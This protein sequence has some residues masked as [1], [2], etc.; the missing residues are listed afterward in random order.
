MNTSL[1]HSQPATGGC[2][3]VREFDSLCVRSF[4]VQHDFFF[5]IS[6]RHLK[7]CAQQI[8]NWLCRLFW[9]DVHGSFD[10]FLPQYTVNCLGIDDD[11]MANASQDIDLIVRLLFCYSM[12]VNRNRQ[13]GFYG[14]NKLCIIQ[15]RQ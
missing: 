1:S 7:Q 9:S 15:W 2:A 11:Q 3:I 12:L 5:I 13:L 6:L 10:G 8:A 14:P 4:S